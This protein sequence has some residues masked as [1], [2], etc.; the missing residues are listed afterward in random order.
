MLRSFFQRG[1]VMLLLSTLVT[2]AA[3][4]CSRQPR[5]DAPPVDGDDIVLTV[6]ELPHDVPVFYTLMTGGR[7]VNFFVIRMNDGVHA[8]LDACV[9]CYQHRLGYAS[10]DGRVICRYC[11]T[12]FSIYKLEKGI[13]GC[14]PIRIPGRT[15]VGRYRIRRAAIE[16]ESFRF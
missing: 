15:D 12:E 11:S 6:G 4:G 7:P 1:A 5:Y 9:S 13:G 10:R 16:A 3:A 2:A 14:Y 8:Y